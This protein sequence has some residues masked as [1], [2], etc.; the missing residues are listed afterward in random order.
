MSFHDGFEYD[1]LSDEDKNILDEY[2]ERVGMT[3]DE[4]WNW[5]LSATAGVPMTE[6]PFTGYEWD[7]WNDEPPCEKCSACK[8]NKRLERKPYGDIEKNKKTYTAHYARDLWDE[9]KDL[10]RDEFLTDMLITS[11]PDRDSQDN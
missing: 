3:P 8:H 7:G 11:Y 9:S 5:M 4:Y 6:D 1:G 10:D 2:A